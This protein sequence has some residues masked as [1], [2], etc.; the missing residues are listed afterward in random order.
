MEVRYVCFNITSKCNM[1]C[2]YC[3]RVGPS[4][5]SVNLEK[6]KEFIDFLVLHNCKTI[7]ITGGEPL[8]IS[9]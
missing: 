8:L 1:E 4:Y 7:N 3:Y 9:E 2:P 5:G 6:A